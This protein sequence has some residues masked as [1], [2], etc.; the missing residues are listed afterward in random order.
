MHNIIDKHLYEYISEGVSHH[1]DKIITSQFAYLSIDDPNDLAGLKE[2][3][4][5]N[6]QVELHGDEVS[7]TYNNGV[8]LAVR[9]N[10]LF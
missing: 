5:K 3:L 8:T 9:T 7:Y 2:Q 4:R 6:E 10:T 1:V